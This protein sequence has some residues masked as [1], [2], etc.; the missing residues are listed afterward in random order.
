MKRTNPSILLAAALFLFP[1]AS[2]WTQSAKP[3]KAWTGNQLT[4]GVPKTQRP[5]ETVGPI[6]DWKA[7]A[8][9]SVLVLQ[10]G[11]VL[12]LKGDS[13]LHKFEMGAKTLSGSA[14]VKASGS[15][16]KAVQA[17][18]V[19]AMALEVPV[20]QLKSKEKGL[21]ENAYKALK[22]KEFPTIKFALDSLSVVKDALTAKG[23][24][25]ISGTTLPVTLTGTAEFTGKQV[26]VKGSAKLKMSDYKVTPPSISILVT[27]IDVKDEVEVV[28]DVIFAPKD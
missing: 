20:E 7:L 17:G 8:G 3:T 16:E 12:Y 14:A 25:T 15:L 13:T 10:K 1:A 2:V 26:Q 11:S 21:D 9:A 5:A 19:V 28:F 22:T 4:G 24:L 18:S 27:S 6:K 23:K